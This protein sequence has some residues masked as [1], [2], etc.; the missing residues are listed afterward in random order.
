MKGLLLPVI[1]FSGITAYAQSG[2]DPL[3]QRMDEMR[4]KYGGRNL[5][6]SP[7]HPLIKDSLPA[8]RS[9]LPGYPATPGVHALPLD[10]MPCVV[11]D[12]KGIATLP[13]A[14]QKPLIPFRSSIPNAIPEIPADRK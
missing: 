8:R 7:A 1:L 10:N 5:V 2:G 11:P 4:K 14:F 9:L 3:K 6:V 13:N 12:T